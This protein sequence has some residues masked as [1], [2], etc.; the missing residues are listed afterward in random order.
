MPSDRKHYI[1]VKQSASK[2]IFCCC[3]SFGDAYVSRAS[4]EDSEFYEIGSSVEDLSGDIA[5]VA[6]SNSMACNSQCAVANAQL[7]LLLILISGCADAY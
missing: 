5:T 3:I 2:T 7:V 1:Y 4:V 6:N